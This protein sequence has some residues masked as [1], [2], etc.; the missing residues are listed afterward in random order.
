MFVCVVLYTVI[1]IN[2]KCWQNVNFDFENNHIDILDYIH[3]NVCSEVILGGTEW[4]YSYIEYTY[5]YNYILIYFVS[6]NCMLS[7]NTDIGL[8]ATFFSINQVAGC[9]LLWSAIADNLVSVFIYKTV[10][11]DD[12]YRNFRSQHISTFF[13]MYHPEISEIDSQIY[14]NIVIN[15]ITDVMFSI[16]N[17]IDKEGVLTPIDLLLQIFIFVYIFTAIISFF[18]SYF[19]SNTKEESTI[20]ID[21]LS[22]SASVESEKELGSFDDY[23]L[24]F[25]IV[26]YFFG[27]FYCTTCW[28]LISVHPDIIL[29]FMSLIPLYAVIWCIPTLLL[30]DFGIVYNAY[31][32]GVALSSLPVFELMYDYLAIFAFFVR[33]LIQGVRL[34]LIFFTYSVMHDAVVYTDFFD[35]GDKSIERFW[36]ELSKLNV[37]LES[38]S[39]FII[40]VL[41]GYYFYFLYELVH[42]FFIVTGQTIAYFAMIF[43]LFL[44]LYTLFVATQFELF[45]KEKKEFRK[46][47]LLDL[48]KIKISATIDDKKKNFFK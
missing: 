43:W 38:L 45:F 14:N 28:N 7:D 8:N 4:I 39:Y 13:V 26:C 16:F 31:L 15:T 47:I 36:E 42:T 21:Y 10:T 6:S 34:I 1:C 22:I 30:Y 46:K 29:P 3:F 37:S 24:T 44:F 19:F 27:Y 5:N 12:F 9:Q 11:C 23:I 18:T 20:D 33:I 32:K 25:V 17:F 35:T 48:K 40:F 41:P 2:I